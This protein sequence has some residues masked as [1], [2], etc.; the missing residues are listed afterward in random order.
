VTDLLTDKHLESVDFF[1]TVDH[2][3]EGRLRMPRLPITFTDVD[4][5]DQRPAPRLG[6]HGPD[7][8]RELGYPAEEVASMVAAGVVVGAGDG[9]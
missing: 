9:K 5:E 2:P 3:T 4:T 1:T 8:L 6:E 7:L